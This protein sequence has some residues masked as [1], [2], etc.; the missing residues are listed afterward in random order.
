MSQI[1]W[2]VAV[3]GLGKAESCMRLLLPLLFLCSP[4]NCSLCRAEKASSPW[5]CDTLIPWKGTH[6]CGPCTFWRIGNRL[7]LV[8]FHPSC[9]VF[10]NYPAPVT[11]P[12][13]PVAIALS[14]GRFALCA[15]RGTLCR[16]AEVVFLLCGTENPLREHSSGLTLETPPFWHFGQTVESSWCPQKVT[17]TRGDKDMPYTSTWPPLGQVSV[18]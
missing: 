18:R 1:S 12:L 17:Q 5:V 14:W 15:W 10:Q 11:M 2:V 16:A 13:L 9:L 3:S 8:A 4:F 7:P 6:C